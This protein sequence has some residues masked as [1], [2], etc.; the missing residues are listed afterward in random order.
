MKKLLT[1]V[2]LV[3]GMCLCTTALAQNSEGSGK[4]TESKSEAKKKAEGVSLGKQADFLV[5]LIREAG[6]ERYFDGPVTGGSAAE[7]LEGLGFAPEGGWQVSKELT[8]EGLRQAYLKVTRVQN[9]AG[10]KYGEA[11]SLEAMTLTE[12]IDAVTKAVEEAFAAISSERM[13]VSP[14]GSVTWPTA[15]PTAR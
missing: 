12:L 6:A 14:T 2:V 9:R 1:S 10:E 3:C 11:P 15:W 5:K 7:K 8:L 13:P 4:E